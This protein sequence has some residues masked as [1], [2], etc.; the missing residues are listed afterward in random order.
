ME[1]NSA[2]LYKND[3]IQQLSESLDQSV[4]ERQQLLIQLDNFKEQVA[5]LQQKVIETSKMVEEHKCAQAESEIQPQNKEAKPNSEELLKLRNEVG[6]L[7]V[8]TCHLR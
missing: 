6:D 7:Q 4:T 2:I 1:Y 3:L 5:Q 8:N